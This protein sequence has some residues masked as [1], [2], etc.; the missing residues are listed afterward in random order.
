MKTNENKSEIDEIKKWE[1]NIKR[2]KLY[3]KTKTK[4]YKYDFQ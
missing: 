3:Y 4:K 2:K 1:E